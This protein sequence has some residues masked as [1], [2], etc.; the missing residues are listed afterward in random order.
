MPQGEESHAGKEHGSSRD[1]AD[2][3]AAHGSQIQLPDPTEPAQTPPEALCSSRSLRRGRISQEQG[4]NRMWAGN[5]VGKDQETKDS[6]DLK[7]AG[8]AGTD[9]HRARRAR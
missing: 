6:A 8:E 5:R 4:L 3:P 9:S 7:D 1:T 2:E